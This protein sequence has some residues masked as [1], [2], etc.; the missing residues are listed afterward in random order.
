MSRFLLF[1][2]RKERWKSFPMLCYV[3]YTLVVNQIY[4]INQDCYTEATSYTFASIWKYQW[5]LP[6]YSINL[7]EFW[8]INKNI[9][10]FKACCCFCAI[11]PSRWKILL[12]KNEIPSTLLINILFSISIFIIYFVLNK[13]RNL[14]SIISA[15]FKTHNLRQERRKKKIENFDEK[16]KNAK[17]TKWVYTAWFS[18][19]CLKFSRKSSTT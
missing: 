8:F 15:A 6:C 19:W 2:R 17:K 1:W 13:H 11:L 4:L 3:F 10:Y 5:L 9:F 14:T 18:V 16:K 12:C 7:Y